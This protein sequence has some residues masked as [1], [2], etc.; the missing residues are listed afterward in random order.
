MLS[1]KNNVISNLEIKHMASIHKKNQMWY[2]AY[3][4][5]QGKRHF[6][7]SGILHSPPGLDAKDARAKAAQ[8]KAKAKIQA[9]KTE[10]FARGNS[11]LRVMRKQYAAMVLDARATEAEQSGIT[12]NGF[13][14]DWVADKL[15][16]G[17]SV[18]YHNHLKNCHAE[19]R[20]ALGERIDE[21]IVQVDE[22]DIDEV[23]DH[24]IAKHL[25]GNSVNKRVHVLREMFAAAEAKGYVIVNPVI[26]RHFQDESPLERQPF[27]PSQLDAV[28]GATRIVNW[29]TA[30]LFGF[31]VGMRLGDARSQT[32]AAID[33]VRRIITWVPIKTKRRRSRKAKI[34]VT[35]IHPVLFAHLLKVYEMSTKM[36][37]VTPSLVNRPLTNLSQE[38][39]EFVRS[40]GVDALPT[41]MPNGRTVRM[42]TFHSTRHAFATELKR[43]GTPDKERSLLTGHA[44][45][46][47]R[48]DNEPISQVAQIYNHVDCAD[49]RKWIDLLPSLHLPPVINLN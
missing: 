48:W 15:A 16:A 38:F 8:A 39:V 43:A 27:M 47:N 9:I 33:W 28:L 5:I 1:L 42:R 32:W 37:A 3:T 29:H 4:D 20:V 2:I 7:S 17:V 6:K 40:A 49:L 24:V 21:E 12:F 44:V 31:Y 34:M 35:P 23:V 25:S 14:G 13:F 22:E 45:A 36:G 46:F 30:T 10:Q 11:R 19:A 26:D 41:K 18:N